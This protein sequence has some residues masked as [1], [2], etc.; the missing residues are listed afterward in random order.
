MPDEGCWWPVMP[1]EGCWWPLLNG[2][3]AC[4]FGL[5]AYSA[6]TW[7]FSAATVCKTECEFLLLTA[8]SVF[9]QKNPTTYAN[10]EDCW[11]QFQHAQCNACNVQK[12]GTG[13]GVIA[14]RGISG[15][16]TRSTWRVARAAQAVC[17][18][19]S[20]RMQ[21]FEHA[22]KHTIHRPR[23]PYERSTRIVR[24]SAHTNKHTFIHRH[25]CLR[26]YA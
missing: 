6:Q 16:Y 26:V 17:L 10:K 12:N 21:R 25:A 15:G 4:L 9:I 2:L 5:V 19:V 8:W 1:D 18:Y 22:Y 11:R 23:L 20:S 24:V 13:H 7:V 3:V 14:R